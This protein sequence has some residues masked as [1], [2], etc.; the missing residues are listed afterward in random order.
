MTSLK[1]RINRIVKRLHPNR[2]QPDRCRLCG[3][4]ESPPAVYTVSE[5]M[6]PMKLILFNG[7]ALPCRGGR[8]PNHC[9]RCG[10]RIQR[11]GIQPPEARL[12]QGLSAGKFEPD[13][14]GE[15]VKTGG[16]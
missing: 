1:A 5:D 13:G 6:V 15:S 12:V 2:Y 16:I 14:N 3:G 7:K 11:V 4:D 9:P 10:R 8:I